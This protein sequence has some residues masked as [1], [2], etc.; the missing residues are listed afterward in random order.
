MRRGALGRAYFSASLQR[1]VAST[2]EQIL[3]ELFR[4]SSFAVET[5]Q[6]DAWTGQI[7]IVR[8]AAAGITGDGIVA[9]EFAVPRM[10]T[11]ID[12]VLVACGA[13]F[14]IE[15]KVGEKEF[16]ADAMRQVWDYALDLKNFHSASHHATI[17]PV[18]VATDADD[19][20]LEIE[21]DQDGVVRPLCTNAQSLGRL[22]RAIAETIPSATID[23]AAWVSG[24][25]RPTPTIIE[26]ARAL[27]GGH[28]VDDI[29]RREADAINLTQTSQCIDSI[30]REARAERRKAICF[31]TGVPGAGK[32][33]VGL[34]VAT[35]HH[36]SRGETHSVF[37]SG[38]GPL[39]A[40]LSEA[41]ARDHVR[42]A[43][44]DGV[45]KPLGKARREVRGFIQNVHHFR[46]ECLRDGELP[47]DDHVA[48]FDEAQRAWNV[49][50]TRS[51]MKTKRQISDFAVSEPAYLVSC[52]DRHPDWAVVVC[53]VGGGQEIHTGEAGIGE[54]LR[55]IRT[56]FPHWHVHLS[57]NLKD[58]EYAAGDSLGLLAGH[59]HVHAHSSLHLGVS[60]RS[61]RAENVSGWVKAILDRDQT[62]ASHALASIRER[63]PIVLTRSL[64]TAKGWL[65]ER[66]RGSERSGIIVSSQAQRLKP[67]AIDVRADID[68]VNWFLRPREDVRSSD[69]LEDAATEFDVQGLELDWTCVVWDGDLRYVGGNWEYW[70]FAG[71][72]W[73]RVRDDSRKS[74]LKN[75]YRVLLTRARQG[76]VIVVPEGDSSD[77][78]RLHAMYDGTFAYLRAMGLREP[79][80]A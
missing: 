13:V 78:T 10:G 32:T 66:A 70:G 44:T 69:F 63:Y 4:S 80:G 25:Y 30:I 17:V 41:L 79:S 64:A 14:V 24:V 18:L 71:S 74:F 59:Q 54:W 43:R 51:F 67:L 6:R 35:R 60:M 7:A 45:R 65:R 49:E 75:A 11:R 53:L 61:F 12:T 8:D 50:R 29:S 2:D 42:R 73:K 68:P 23:G 47:P 46:D 58:S 9:L 26:A 20:P 55:A 62:A 22:I 1:F 77:S 16:T 39:V 72:A 28:G 52:M 19:R 3:A 48:L 27:Y 34:D 38:N 56:E 15:F 31:V 40:V 37:L 21:V 33:L 76:M 57:P 5:T 36:D